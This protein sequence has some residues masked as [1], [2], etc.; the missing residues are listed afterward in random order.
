MKLGKAIGTIGG[1]TMVSRILGM[2]RESVMASVLGANR[3][4]DIFL[5]AFRLPNMF[6]RF[7]GEGAFSAGFVPLF[8]QR[9]NGEGGLEE[10]KAFSE[11]VLAVFLP[12]LAV[13]TLIG[14][15]VMPALVWALA[16]GLP[17][18][19]EAI[20][21]ILSRITFPYLMLI[22]LVSLFSGVLNSMHR[23]TAAAFAPALLNLMM[24][25]AL[26]LV[27]TGGIASVTALAWSVVIGGVIQLGLVWWAARQ[28]GISLRLRKPK[29]TP[30]VK[31]FFLVVFPALIS[32][33]VYQISV[34][35]DTQFLSH[36][37]EGSLSH[38]NYAD[39]LNQLPLGI[40]GTALGT[41]I[42]P[43]ISKFIGHDQPEEANAVQ[44]QALD[45]AMLLT[46]PAAIALA[47]IGIPIVSLV[48][49][50]GEFTPQ[51]A[52]VTGN[53]LALFA[54]GLPAYVLVK[55]FTPAFF[56]R[57]DTRTPLMIA[58]VVLIFNVALNFALVGPFGLYGLAAALM[59]TAWLNCGLLYGVLRKRDHFRLDPAVA[60]RVLRQIAAAAAMGVTLYLCNKGLAG[61]AEHSKIGQLIV[62][63]LLVG[64]GGV[65]YFGVGWGIG[66][67]NRDDVML[68]LR[69]KKPTGVEPNS[70]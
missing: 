33:G 60:G 66:A 16:S 45:L 68:L 67:V 40:V 44:N 56:A 30:G 48:Y 17:S 19:S 13:F 20:A 35:I 58:V 2:A 25:A 69:R 31:Q 52:I 64:I 55:V 15:L 36:L 41:A 63:L 59:L 70:P 54:L 6:R 7:F 65:T 23:F 50:H 21:V 22:S 38:F 11:D 57:K 9:Y 51:D 4:T 29:M 27:P 46:L 26:L 62:P 18:E 42:L 3:Y 28:A 24:L 12:F 34:L 32:A 61:F 37:S 1:L 53:T 8:S 5:V 49:R 10:A 14:Q 43:S 47:V 39:R